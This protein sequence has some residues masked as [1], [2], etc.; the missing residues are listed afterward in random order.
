MDKDIYVVFATGFYEK[1]L[2]TQ[3]NYRKPNLSFD[4]NKIS[5]KKGNLLCFYVFKFDQICIFIKK[6]LPK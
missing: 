3:K 1:E 5:K 2:T 4:L 6:T